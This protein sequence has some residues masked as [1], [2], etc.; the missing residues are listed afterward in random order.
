MTIDRPKINFHQLQRLCFLALL[1]IAQVGFEGSHLRAQVRFELAASSLHAALPYRSPELFRHDNRLLSNFSGLAVS[2]SW[3]IQENKELGVKVRIG[4]QKSDVFYTTSQTNIADESTYIQVMPRLS[5]RLARG[6][7]IDGGPG[8]A[9]ATNARQ[10]LTSLPLGDQLSSVELLDG[11]L[12]SYV[13]GE[14]GLTL[15]GEAGFL[16]LAYHQG[17]SDPHRNTVDYTDLNGVIVEGPRGVWRGIGIDAGV[18]FGWRD[19]PKD[20]ERSWTVGPLA[21]WQRTSLSDAGFFPSISLQTY[22]FVAGPQEVTLELFRQRQ[23]KGIR[24]GAGVGFSSQRFSWR[25]E[26]IDSVVYSYGF[27]GQTFPNDTSAFDP[28]ARIQQLTLPLFVDVRAFKDVRIGASL[29][30]M[31]LLQTTKRSSLVREGI[32]TTPEASRARLDA[33]LTATI[34][35]DR[36]LEMFGSFRTSLTPIFEDDSRIERLGM[37]S[38]GNREIYSSIGVRLKLIE[39]PER[40]TPIRSA[41]NRRPQPTD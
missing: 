21:R 34:F 4:E 15:R 3:R 32:L 39:A 24:L 6:L 25:D 13:F 27:L 35:S 10:T 7:Y 37:F 23:P 41:R 40:T 17:L 1:V 8:F 31:T 36:R 38:F 5:Q 18:H 30:P 33:S 19:D 28:V 12:G 20:V 16:R 22:Y 14:V 11:Q 9:V 29:I 2:T 26:A